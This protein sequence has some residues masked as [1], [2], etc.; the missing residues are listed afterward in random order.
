VAA[1]FPHPLIHRRNDIENAACG[2]KKPYSLSSVFANG[3]NLPHTPNFRVAGDKYN[4]FANCTR[5]FLA[6]YTKKKTHSANKCHTASAQWV[7]LVS[8]AYNLTKGAKKCRKRQN[9]RC[10]ITAQT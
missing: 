1:F 6:A 7:F 8:F 2:E 5:Y 3:T 10:N 4:W 9:L